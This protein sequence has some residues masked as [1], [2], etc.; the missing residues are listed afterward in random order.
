LPGAAEQLWSKPSLRWLLV[1]ELHGSNE[2]PTAVADLVCDA[3]ARGRN[4]TVALERPTSEQA[5]LNGIL[6]AKDLIES[7]Q[8]LLELPG[9]RVDGQ[10]RPDGRSSGAMLQLLI[11]L[12]ELH[13]KDADI[14]VAAFDAPYTGSGPGARDEALGNALLAL[15]KS[16]PTKLIVVL[17]GNLHAMQAPMYGYDLAA[18]YLPAE[19]RIS[20]EVTDRGGESWSDSTTGGC[21]LHKNSV[22][23][24][25]VTN[26]R[27]VFLDPALAPYGKVDGI[28]SL[29][30]PLTASSPAA[31]EPSSLLECRIKYLA[32]HRP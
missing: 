10:G 2:A 18:M 26:S 4:V 5:E 9:W 15:G 27:G 23:D 12:R 19:Q 22:G 1:G 25:G 29:G 32:P 31:G 7:E 14:S 24:K 20:L 3:V 28:L 11:A 21:G 8:K 30:A 13:K 17:T 16:Q 6:T